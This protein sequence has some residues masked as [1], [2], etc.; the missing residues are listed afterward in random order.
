MNFNER[1]DQMKVYLVTFGCMYEGMS[2]AVVCS[3]LIKVVE[4]ISEKAHEEYQEYSRKGGKLNYEDF[5][6][7]NDNERTL[8]MESE[9][10]IIR[11]SEKLLDGEWAE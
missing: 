5:A 1:D 7:W 9:Q 10:K 2:M 8:T 6:I 11:I 4:A 3:S